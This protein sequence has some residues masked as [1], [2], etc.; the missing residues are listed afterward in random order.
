MSYRVKDTITKP[1]DVLWFSEAHP[2]VVADINYWLV[3]N[4]GFIVYQKL[5][6]TPTSLVKV[7]EFDT[8][9]NYK[10]YLLARESNA[11]EIQRKTYNISNGITSTHEVLP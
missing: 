5:S 9:E 7:Y 4:P 10:A 1:A 3:T 8:E 2:E 6:V 11:A